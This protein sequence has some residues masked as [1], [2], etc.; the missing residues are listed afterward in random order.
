MQLLLNATGN[1]TRITAIIIKVMFNPETCQVPLIR[2]GL[3][4]LQN[5]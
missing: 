1:P 5:Q 3:R 2:M 4:A